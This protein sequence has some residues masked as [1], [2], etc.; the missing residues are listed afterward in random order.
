MSGHLYSVGECGGVQEE[1][2]CPTCGHTIGGK[3]YSVAKGNTRLDAEPALYES[4]KQQVRS[5]GYRQPNSGDY[6]INRNERSEVPLSPLTVALLR[7]MIHSLLAFALSTGQRLTVETPAKDLML[8]Q[9]KQMCQTDWNKIVRVLQASPSDAAL[10]LHHAIREQL[11]GVLSAGPSSFSG[12]SERMLVQWE[13]YFQSQFTESLLPSPERTATLQHL[14]NTV[15][16]ASLKRGLQLAY[17]DERLERLMYQSA[18]L[19]PSLLQP[20]HTFTLQ[21]LEEVFSIRNENA[22]KFGVLDMLL[23]RKAELALVELLEHLL[24]WIADVMS[25]LGTAGLSRTAVK[26]MTNQTIVDQLEQRDPQSNASCRLNAFCDAFNAVLPKI[27]FIYRCTQNPFIHSSGCVDLSFGTAAA[28]VAMERHTSLSFSVPSMLPGEVDAQGLCTIQICGY[29]ARL[30]NTLVGRIFTSVSANPQL[31][32]P[33]AVDHRTSASKLQKLL[34]HCDWTQ[35]LSR[36]ASVCSAQPVMGQ[37]CLE[38]TVFEFAAIE[39]QL[40][41][42]LLK[43]GCALVQLTLQ[44]YG[45]VGELRQRGALSALALRTPQAAMSPDQINR[46]Q[47]GLNTQEQIR[48]LAAIVED[49]IQFAG[50]LGAGAGT[51][52][53]DEYVSAVLMLPSDKWASVR[54]DVDGLLVG[55]LRHLFLVLE[56]MAGEGGQSKLPLCYRDGLDV[57]LEG[58]LTLWAAEEGEAA[59]VLALLQELL[60]GPL[61]EGFLSTDGILKDYIAYQAGYGEAGDSEELRKFPE[62][63]QLRHAQSAYHLLLSL[64]SRY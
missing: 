23:K 64:V 52:A 30:H 33:V 60:E 11:P 56:E 37:P 57:D 20:R 1:S 59:A 28:P 35:E 22:K 50:V 27:E 26:E 29:L 4:G 24:A 51:T 36:A 13:G 10:L 6:T 48:A 34:L 25:V 47:Q 39:S 5:P 44:H 32:I 18:E 9:I 62:V 21:G 45:Y 49:C 16:Q 31:M 38:P 53:L 58:L 42:S 12:K 15:A 19:Q 63:L 8:K 40:S 61:Q 3:H 41:T 14:R 7:F 17:G 55:H 2:R 43:H 54:P 46:L